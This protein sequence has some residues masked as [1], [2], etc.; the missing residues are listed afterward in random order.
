MWTLHIVPIKDKSSHSPIICWTDW[1]LSPRMET[2]HLQDRVS[3]RHRLTTQCIYMER[4]MIHIDS[5]H[6]GLLFWAKDLVLCVC[7]CACAY[8]CASLLF[9]HC[10]TLLQKAS[11]PIW[12]QLRV[13]TER[14][15]IQLPLIQI[16]C[17]MFISEL[18]KTV[19][20]QTTAFLGNPPFNLQY[21]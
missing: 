3:I 2:C 21:E 16:N 14:F 17:P 6:K 12:F 10:F 18:N 20:K 4:V 1:D 9:F 8:A 13:R 7:V 19:L 5:S 11:W 15:L